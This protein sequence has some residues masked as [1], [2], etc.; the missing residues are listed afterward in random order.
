[1]NIRVI[2]KLK[3]Y[4]LMAKTMKLLTAKQYKDYK[5]KVNA[6]ERDW[7]KKHPKEHSKNSKE[8]LDAIKGEKKT[9]TIKTKKVKTVPKKTVK[10]IAKKIKGMVEIPKASE[11]ENRELAKEE[12][13]NM[14]T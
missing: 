14:T 13:E 9:K 10:K 8:L 12:R 6:Y 4:F 7:R 3:L 11:Q 1:M 5:S 2:N